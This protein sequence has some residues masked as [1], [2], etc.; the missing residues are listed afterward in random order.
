MM[1]DSAVPQPSGKQD[2]SYM[3]QGFDNV[4]VCV[5]DLQRSVTFYEMLGLREEY[6][7][8]RGVLM[9]TG[10]ARLFL[11]ASKRVDQVLVGRELGLFQNPP[12]IDHIS[13]AVA[14]VDAIYANLRKAGVEF[15]GEPQDQSWGARM[16]GLKD[17][18]G[19]NLYLLQKLS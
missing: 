3:V 14:D 4:G 1:A 2:A 19:N 13:F 16:V 18:D 6:R 10:S 8:E 5:T 15:D 7:N 12:G 11:F 9:S 17:P